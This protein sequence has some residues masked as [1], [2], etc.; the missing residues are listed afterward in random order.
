MKKIFSYLVT[1]LVFIIAWVHNNAETSPISKISKEW[2]FEVTPCP[3][4]A[5]TFKF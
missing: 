5:V 3:Q 4:V 2:R 1:T